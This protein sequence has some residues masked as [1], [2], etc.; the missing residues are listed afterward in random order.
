MTDAGSSI[1][2]LS[3]EVKHCSQN[4]SHPKTGK[5]NFTVYFTHRRCKAKKTLAGNLSVVMIKEIRLDKKQALYKH[6]TTQ[7]QQ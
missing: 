2:N 6:R 7:Q 5:L 3:A 1:K 4:T